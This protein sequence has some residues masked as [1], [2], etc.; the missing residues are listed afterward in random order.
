MAIE[1]DTELDVFFN[2]NDFA[3]AASYTL[4][5]GETTTIN[6]IFDNEYLGEESGA[7]VVFAVSQPRFMVKTSDLPSGADE[8]DGLVVSGTDYLVKVIER[9]GTGVTMLVLEKQ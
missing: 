8:G 1:T 5:G 2:V 4:A 9:D 7:G 3:V 6:G